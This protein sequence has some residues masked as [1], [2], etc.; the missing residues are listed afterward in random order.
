M[1]KHMARI[2]G[3]VRPSYVFVENSPMLTIRGLGVVLADLSS[4]GFD[5]EWGVVSEKDTG[6]VH[7]RERIWIV[8][9]NTREKR[10][11]RN[12]KKAIPQFAT[13]PWGKDCRSIE[14][15]RKRT[16]LFPSPIHRRDYGFPDYVDRIAAL[17]NA[18]I[19][20]VAATAWEVLK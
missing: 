19:P 13:F 6:A 1:W 18:Q 17:G 4:L 11:C 12:I 16:E 2:V 10:I 8:A 14:D 7:L 5:A 3:E 9:T 15:L 20:R